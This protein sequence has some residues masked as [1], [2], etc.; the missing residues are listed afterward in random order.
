[1]IYLDNAATSYK[2][3]DAVIS[4]TCEALRYK[5]AN[6]GRS[7]HDL[8]I[9]AGEVLYDARKSLA[10]LFNVKNPERIVFCHNTTDAL[11]KGIK[12]VMMGGGHVITTSMEHNS[13]I[14]PIY[15]LK[16]TGVTHSVLRGNENGV[17]D[18]EELDNMIRRDTKLIVMTSASNV[19]GNI[20]DI[21]KASEIAHKKGVLLMID[22]AQG[23]GCID[24]DCS[25][26]D[27]IA[28]PGHKGLLAPMG[29]GGL[30][31]GENVKIEPIIE[32]GT[33]SVS[34]SL[35]Q[36]DFFPDI[37]ESGTMN[38]ASI[39][40][41]GAAAEFIQKK[42]INNIYAHEVRLRS[43]FEEKLRASD[44]ITIYGDKNRCGICAFNILGRDCVDVAQILNDRYKI[45][46]RAGLHCAYLAHKTLKTEKTGC[47]R[48]SFGLFNTEKE[49]RFL[50]EAVLEI[51]KGI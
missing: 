39:A 35:I 21:K 29:T 38:V 36:P 26:V 20:Y 8:S 10:K 22:V 15:A 2:K 49:A 43:I 45:C 32:G 3:P 51:A 4:A 1:M 34:E 9:L 13:V 41:L 42:G 6:P 17:F 25:D 44:N 5:C 31:V 33:G 19:C 30:Y 50:Q 7:G 24:I 11:N 16:K 23:A 28:F 37:L 27:L 40:G 12:G 46:V 18:I 47:V 14:R 48:A